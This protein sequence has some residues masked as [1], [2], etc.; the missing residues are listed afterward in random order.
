MNNE[1]NTRIGRPRSVDPF[2]A[3]LAT[4]RLVALF[5]PGQASHVRIAAKETGVPVSEFMRNAVLAA[6]R[7]IV[8]DLK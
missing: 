8:H 5:T 6:A 2:E 7:N 1:N 3:E 4:E